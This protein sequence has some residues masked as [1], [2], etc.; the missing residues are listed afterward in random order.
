ML[1]VKKIIL[2]TFVKIKGLSGTCL[3][4]YLK[5]FFHPLMVMLG[6]N[7]KMTENGKREGNLSIS[8]H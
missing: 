7:Q 6:K 3:F 4:N 5:M 1:K 2:K 8:S